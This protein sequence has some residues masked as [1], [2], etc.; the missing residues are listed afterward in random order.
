MKSPHAFRSIGEVSQ[1]VGVATHVLRYWETQFPALAPVRRPDG[2]R[3]YRLDDL[4]LAAGLCEVMREEG[5]TIRGARRLIAMDKG[6]GLRDRGRARL[7]GALG[8]DEPPEPPEAAVAPSLTP[9]AAELRHAPSRAIDSADIA[10][11]RGN[12][13]RRVKLAA[14]ADALPLFPEL[15][16]AS[17]AAAIAI[18]DATGSDSDQDWLGRLIATAAALRDRPVPPSPALVDLHAAL[19]D[20]RNGAR[21][22]ADVLP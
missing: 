7:G 11:A 2:R 19:H 17:G 10:A 6:T 14:A 4:L 1:L 12:S 5:L 21:K 9:T 3:Y 18:R 20:A 22:S 16:A 13:G 15:D 8:L